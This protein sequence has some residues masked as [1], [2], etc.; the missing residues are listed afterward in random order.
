MMDSST[1]KKPVEVYEGTI[2]K[3][4][5]AAVGTV[6]CSCIYVADM[7]SKKFN[8]VSVGGSDIIP[9]SL[10]AIALVVGGGV[11]GDKVE[12]WCSQNTLDNDL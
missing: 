3:P 11:L 4:L 12:K 10:L 2:G 6:A 1:V 9:H 5:G 8:M 7:L